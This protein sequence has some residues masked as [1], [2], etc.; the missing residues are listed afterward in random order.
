MADTGNE[1]LRFLKAN[2][3]DDYSKLSSDS[4]SDSLVNAVFT[5]HQSHFENWQK[6][7]E[8]IRN[9]Y[10]D[11]VPSDILQAASTDPNLTDAEI[12]N[13]EAGRYGGSYS[14]K[15]DDL[16]FKPED[17]GAI[18]ANAHIIA[19]KGYSAEAASSLA[20]AKQIRQKLKTDPSLKL[21]Q[22][23]RKQLWRETREN[24]RK[25]IKKDWCENQSEK[26]AVHILKQLN[27]GHMDMETALPQLDM[28]IKNIKEKNL[29]DSF[30]AYIQTPQSGF[31]RLKPEVKSLLADLAENNNVALTQDNAQSIQQIRNRIG[32]KQLRD[33]TNKQ[34]AEA[35]KLMRLRQ[36]SQ[37]G[38]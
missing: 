35:V 20:Y 1:F 16:N 32:S 31:Q 37:L 25:T 34:Q 19:D 33:S 29:E 21:P 15:P 24:D 5:K 6:V 7:P 17:F 30:K 22:D 18:M 36:S 38:S 4:V 14:V 12:R 10:A 26:M 8:W 3:P 28:M 9:K 2:H 13:L 11:R 27:R 23:Q